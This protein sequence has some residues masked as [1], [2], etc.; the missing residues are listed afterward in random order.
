L[1]KPSSIISLPAMSS[2]SK[3][4]SILE[5]GGAGPKYEQIGLKS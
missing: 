2:P 3:G 5:S 4:E 1:S